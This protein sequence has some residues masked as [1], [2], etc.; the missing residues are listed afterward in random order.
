MKGIRK[1]FG[2]FKIRTKIILLYLTVL[3]LSFLM[4]FTIISKVNEAYTKREVGNTGIQ[5]LNALKGN[6]TLVFENVTQFSN[7]IYFD[8]NVQ[9]SLKNI[10]SKNINPTIQRRITKSLINMLLSG[11]YISSVFIFD[12]Y[13]NYYNTY[14][15]GPISVHNEK[16]GDTQWYAKMQEANGNGFFIHKSEGILEFPT[17]RDKNYITYIKEIGAVN[18]YEPLATLMVTVDEA[19]IQAYFEE[20]SSVHA[21]QFFIV[22]GAGNYIIP[23][24]QYEEEYAEYITGKK[25]S[26]EVYETV[27]IKDSTVIMVGQEMGI[28]DW[29]LVGS[30]QL[31]NR[32]ALTPYYTT[33]IILIMCLNIIFVFICSMA[34]TRFIFTP[35]AKLEKHMKMVEEGEFIPVKLD[36]DQN[37]INSLKK[38]FNHMTRS[39]QNLIE[40]V[41]AEE[42]IIAKGELD[43]IQAQ[44]NPHFLY[45]TL[46]A[47]SA[48][49]LMKDNENCFKMTQALGSFYRN[50]LNSGMDFVTISEEIQCIRSYIT[51]LNIRYD[52]KIKVKYEVEEHLLKHKILK[53]LLQPLIENAV[54]HGIKGNNGAGNILIKIFEDEEEIILIVS[55][56]GVGMTEERARAIMDEKSVT[57]KPGFG[58]YSLKQRITLYYGIPNPIMIHSEVEG[59]CEIT[60][61]VKK[62]EEGETI[63]H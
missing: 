54:H 1:F 12:K 6:L 56:D 61:R 44:I 46:D 5:T 59:G 10:K 9:A 23:P 49:A 28:A 53:L 7:L 43:L 50:S 18:T 42:K 45:N 52:D 14:K 35:L 24:S 2:R 11:D 36:G 21:S 37:E 38:V 34:L 8:D 33:V 20:V 32:K 31:D 13:N 55:D 15:V 22:D 47:V 3:L 39:I 29:K 16:L 60:V 17:R 57:G 25:I 27:K 63:E 51:I 40:E 30:F 58:I 4:T 62:I 41:K 48:L 19:T 26:D